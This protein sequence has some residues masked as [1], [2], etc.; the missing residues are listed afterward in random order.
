M[1]GFLTVQTV[2]LPLE[3]ARGISSES[4]PPGAT[5]VESDAGIYLWGCPCAGAGGAACVSGG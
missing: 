2:D 5:G 3:G 1:S 4:L